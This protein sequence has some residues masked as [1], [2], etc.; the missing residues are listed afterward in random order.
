MIK[1]IIFDCFGVV[2]TDS[3]D[4]VYKSMGGDPD[5]D[6]DFIRRT[7]QESNSG[8]IASSRPI[9]AAHLG[10]TESQWAEAM[11]RHGS[12]DKRLLRYIQELGKSYKIAMLSNI[13]KRGLQRFFEPG[14]LE[15]YFEQ[16][17]VSGEIGFAKPEARAYEITADKLGVRIDEC[18][19]I[20]DRQEYVEGA[21]F[22][23]MKGVLYK[24]L[25]KCKAELKLILDSSKNNL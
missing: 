6:R 5:K 19:F 13:G 25:E 9:I 20:D 18:I 3:F 16:I 17:I 15:K 21:W 12:I 10:I 7:L 22:V 4:D 2:R 23:G 14:F 1:A 11:N 8:R 24:S